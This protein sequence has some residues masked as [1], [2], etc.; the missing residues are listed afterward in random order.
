MRE[1]RGGF[2]PTLDLYWNPHVPNGGGYV[3]ADDETS[4]AAYRELD[5]GI[6]PTRILRPKPNA[7][8]EASIWLEQRGEYAAVAKT[9]PPGIESY[10]SFI[11]SPDVELNTILALLI[12]RCKDAQRMI[13][14]FHEDASTDLHYHQMLHAVVHRHERLLDS[15]LTLTRTGRV[16]HALGLTRM[17]YEAFLNFY[18]D[19]LSPQF[20]GPRLQLLAALRQQEVANRPLSENDRKPLTNFVGL[21]E[22]ASDKARLSPLGQFYHKAVYPGLSLVA[23]QSY[24]HLE[25]EASFRVDT[26]SQS[27]LPEGTLGHWL[28]IITASLI[29]RVR[30]EVGVP[31]SVAT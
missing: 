6:V 31:S 8:G 18:I 12:D 21:L 30:N 17:A 27:P 16:E 7:L 25:R 22:N 23:H 2:R 14:D 5:I 1:I 19:W 28:D 29:V 3:C 10:S 4:L 26:V 20:F 15:I 24:A 13:V 9:V 11:G